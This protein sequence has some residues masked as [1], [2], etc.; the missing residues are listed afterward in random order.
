MNSALEKTGQ[1]T[2]LIYLSDLDHRSG[3]PDIS[4]AAA[5]WLKYA[6]TIVGKRHTDEVLVP[7]NATVLS[8]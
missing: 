6:N 8:S 2:A 4:S 3:D 5:P 1:T 7:F